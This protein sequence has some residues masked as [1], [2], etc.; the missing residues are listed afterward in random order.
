MFKLN[1]DEIDTMVSQNV[2]PSRKYL[3][4]HTPYVFT[5]QGIAML[6]GILNSTRAIHVNIQIMRT[7][8]KLREIMSSNSEIRNKIEKMEKEYGENFQIIFKA[9]KKLLSEPKKEML[10]SAVRIGFNE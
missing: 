1:E 5:E 7:F 4:G 8:V 2:I 10:P 9:I 6:S 3:G